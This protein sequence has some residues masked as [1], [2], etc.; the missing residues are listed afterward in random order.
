MARLGR[1]FLALAAALAACTDPSPK[2]DAF[3]GTWVFNTGAVAG[4]CQGGATFFPI[5]GSR[6]EVRKRDDGDLD[7]EA[8]CRCHVR[9]KIEGAAA[10]IAVAPT[11]CPVYAQGDIVTSQL[12]TFDF[13]LEGSEA[14]ASFGGETILDS[15]VKPPIACASFNSMGTLMRSDVPGVACG[16]DETAVGVVS[17]SP[18]DGTTDC[19]TGSGRD[20]VQFF[21]DDENEPTQVFCTHDTGQN[22]EGPWVFPDA[23]KYRPPCN[24]GKDTVLFFCRVDGAL[25]K[26]TSADPRAVEQPYALLQ[27]G[28][29]C[30]PGS[31]SVIKLFSTE[32]DVVPPLHS[33]AVGAIGPNDLHNGDSNTAR[34]AF[35]Y[36]NA[37]LAPGDTMRA[38]P[39]LGFPYAVF[40]DFEGPQ[41]SWVLAKRWHYSDN[42]DVTG[43]NQYVP[44]ALD[45]FEDV[46]E[47]TNADTV[48]DMARVR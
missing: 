46:I 40:H 44:P 30:P 39:D 25:F 3:V 31:V 28:T 10:H 19:P 27:L 17:A 13:S 6:L 24:P 2:S 33:Y 29:R 8:S 42:E 20:G 5:I 11:E 7:V 43:H 32:T 23:A 12:T 41:P 15:V 36:F 26:Q 47:N 1:A 45:R 22:G 21:I 34:L 38:F 35:C 14:R 48:F 16:S 18:M 37:A 4:N 9:L